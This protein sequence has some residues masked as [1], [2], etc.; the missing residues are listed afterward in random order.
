MTTN[1]METVHQG[2]VVEEYRKRK[3]WSREK[4]AAVLHIDTSTVYRMEQQRVIRSIERRRMLMG[5]LGIPAAFMELYPDT[6]M[7]CKPIKWNDDHMAFFE[8]G[9]TIRGISTILAERGVRIAVWISGYKSQRILHGRLQEP[10]G[11][12]VLMRH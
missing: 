1:A 8:E 5:L 11:R 9:I 12:S 6:D 2:K 3:N 10:H 7:L 4:L